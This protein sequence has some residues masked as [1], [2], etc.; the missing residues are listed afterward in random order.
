LEFPSD[1]GAD[2]AEKAALGA[3]KRMKMLTQTRHGLNLD[4]MKL[5]TITDEQ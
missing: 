2:S 5:S 3:K 1:L 4:I